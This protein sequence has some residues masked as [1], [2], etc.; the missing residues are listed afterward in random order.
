[1]GEMKSQL[2]KMTKS[3]GYTS[4]HEIDERIQELEMKLQTEVMKLKDEKDIMKEMS[5]L[6]RSRPKVAQING[7]KDSLATRD[8]GSALR[9]NIGSL[10]EEMALYRD[11]KRKVQ[12]QLSALN[13]SRKEQM[14]D[15]PQIIEQK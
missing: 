12:E 15:L 2:Q 5:D 3:F 4:E 13:E 8:T 1:M 10:N 14:G 11:G 6:R 7:M 9:E